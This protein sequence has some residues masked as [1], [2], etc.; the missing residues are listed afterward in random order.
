MW[1]HLQNIYNMAINFLPLSVVP[2]E[3]LGVQP[4]PEIPKTH[5]NRAKINPIV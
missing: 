2:R 4:P 3:R 5:Q 1:E